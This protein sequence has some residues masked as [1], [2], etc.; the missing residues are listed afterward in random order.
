[1]QI[2]LIAD[3]YKEL[4]FSDQVPNALDA[5]VVPGATAVSA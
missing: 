2:R 5:Y 3:N 1:M 4:V